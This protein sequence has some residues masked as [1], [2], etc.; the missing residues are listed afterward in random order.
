MRQLPQQ[1]LMGARSPVTQQPLE[2]AAGDL[3]ASHGLLSE[4]DGHLGLRLC[5]HGEDRKAAAMAGNETAPAEVE[6]VGW[7]RTGRHAGAGL[8]SGCAQTAGECRD[9][10]RHASPIGDDTNA[11]P[12][13]RAIRI[14]SRIAQKM[15]REI[16]PTGP[17][18]A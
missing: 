18:M 1:Q 2:A 5:F 4:T 3:V 17:R 14:A 7:N 11:H 12:E 10:A 6:A 15:R 13:S 8:Q 16:H 9:I